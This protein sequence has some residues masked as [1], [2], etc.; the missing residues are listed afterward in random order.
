MFV[1]MLFCAATL[2]VGEK[3]SEKPSAPAPAVVSKA[4]PKSSAAPAL[5]KKPA[6]APKPI[7]SPKTA[8]VFSDAIQWRAAAAH[9]AETAKT[10]EPAGAVVAADSAD[11]EEEEARPASYVDASKPQEGGDAV[12]PSAKI[13]LIAIE[14]NIVDRTNE[15]RARH[16]LPPLEVDPNLM[17]SAREHARW[18][19]LTQ[20]LQHTRAAVAENI[21]MGQPDSHSVLRSWMGS[22]GH[23]AN[24]LNGFHGKIGVAAFRTEGGTI[25]WCQQFAN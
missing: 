7:L 2:A 8:V 4:A 3:A 14:R 6:Q 9:A 15:E 16:G 1:E 25:F 23:R 17:E 11:S 10:A 5:L 12:K 21:A 13:D 24:I 20:R 19:S 18:M 22:S